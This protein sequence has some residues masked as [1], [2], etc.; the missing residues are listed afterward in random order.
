MYFCGAIIFGVVEM[1]CRD[2]K[3]LGT[4]EGDIIILQCNYF[5]SV[6]NFIVHCKTTLDTKIMNK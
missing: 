5:V 6:T 4:D 2:D 1:I 3:N